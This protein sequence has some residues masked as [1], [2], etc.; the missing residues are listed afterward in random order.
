MQTLNQ[1][2]QLSLVDQHRLVQMQSRRGAA[3]SAEG[4]WALWL[5]DADFIDRLAAERAKLEREAQ[6]DEARARLLDAAR[7]FTA[8]A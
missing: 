4:G 5:L 6:I 1:L 2:E 8:A 7:W 3:A